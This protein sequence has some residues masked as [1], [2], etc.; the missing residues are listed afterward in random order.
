MAHCIDRN[1]IKQIV[2]NYAE[3]LKKEYKLRGVYLYGSYARGNFT[4]DSDIDIV[5]VAEDFTGDL[6]EDTFRLMKLR[7]KVDYR[8]EPHPFMAELFN[9]SNPDAREIMVNGIRIV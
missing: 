7:R 5:V 8:I 1:K 9:E 4:K 2:L 3:H 6:V